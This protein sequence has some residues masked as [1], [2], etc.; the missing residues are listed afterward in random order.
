MFLSPLIRPL[1]LLRI[2]VILIPLILLISII[3]PFLLRPFY[4]YPCSYPLLLPLPPSLGELDDLMLDDANDL[5]DDYLADTGYLA[6]N[7]PTNELVS[8]NGSGNGQRRGSSEPTS[9]EAV[10]KRQQWRSSFQDR[11][12]QFSTWF[13]HRN[14]CS[15]HGICE[16]HMIGWTGCAFPFFLFEVILKN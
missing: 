9:P 11:M 14:T 6:E 5:A 2:L 3:T 7:R 4:F 12:S 15:V 16:C 10:A 1:L 8:I 13:S